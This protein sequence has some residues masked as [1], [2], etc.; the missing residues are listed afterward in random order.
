MNQIKYSCPALGHIE[1]HGNYHDRYHLDALHSITLYSNKFKT[2]LYYL[3]SALLGLANRLSSAPLIFFFIIRVYLLWLQ[4][5]LSGYKYFIQQGCHSHRAIIADWVICN[6]CLHKPLPQP[7]SVC[8]QVF[9]CP[10]T[11]RWLKKPRM[12]NV[13]CTMMGPIWR[14][15]TLP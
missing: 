3:D 11:K 8:V 10:H 14:T 6:N 2:L 12:E 4:G 1:M 15:L 9:T 5:L 7:T 13:N